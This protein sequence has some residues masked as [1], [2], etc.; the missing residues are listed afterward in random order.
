MMKIA[1]AGFRHGHIFAL[2]NQVKECPDV[3]IAGSWEENEEARKAAAEKSGVEFDG[4][5]FEDLLAD[6]S[7]DMIAV[8]DYYGRRGELCIRA[9]EAGKHVIADK[10]ICTSL[11]ELDRIETDKGKY[12]ALLPIFDDAD[13]QLED[14]GEIII[15][16]V[17]EENGETYLAAIEDD[18]EFEEVG[19]LFEDRLI[20]LFELEEGESEE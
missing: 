7:I 2:Y 3:E 19:N 20:D 14:S 17:S 16:K 18:A 11:E 13:D 1:F 15:L 8:G 5:S 6:D 4:R 10:P 9:L 12:V